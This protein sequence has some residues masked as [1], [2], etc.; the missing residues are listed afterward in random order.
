M[1]LDLDAN[2]TYAC[3][4]EIQV[5]IAQAMAQ[6]GN[7][8]SVHRGGQRARAAVEEA[9]EGIRELVGA[10]PGDQIV[11][12]SGA[13][14]ANNTVVAA[15]TRTGS[16]SLVSTQIEHPS[17]LAPLAREALKGRDVRLVAP[18][19]SGEIIPEAIV[20][21]LGSETA[22]ISVMMAN[23]ETGVC[24]PIMDI[25]QRAREHAPRALIH[26]D[27]S[28]VVGK[29]ALSFSEMGIDIGTISG[30]KIGALAGV[31]ALVLRHGV[32][33]E[34]LVVGGSQ[35]MKLRG[36][37]ENVLGIIS[38][39]I[40]SRLV[41]ERITRRSAQMRAV[42]DRFELLVLKE[43]SNCDING[44]NQQ[45]LPNTSNIFIQGVRGDD[46]VVALDLERILVSSGA[47][48]SS[49]KPEPSHVLLAMGQDE[50]RVRSTVRVSFRADQSE[51][52]AE[53][54]AHT[55]VRIAKRMRDE[56]RTVSHAA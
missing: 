19:Q 43:L 14:E 28:Q 12:T 52:D 27:L 45:R 35:E 8:S 6:L 54:V 18:Q 34:P 46:L 33:I 25:A 2:A 24:N 1:F 16:G 40:A 48:C 23:N 44:M 17:I 30:H 26:S 10:L 5:L 42:R 20:S 7:P 49:G 13:T 39:G 15:A 11:F 56:E 37:T 50:Q 22:L 31:G 41:R 53:R 3:D 29:Q 55:L 4:E 21:G 9:R 38:L 51:Q 36:G 32:P 47:A